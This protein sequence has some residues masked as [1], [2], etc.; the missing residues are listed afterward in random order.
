MNPASVVVDTGPIRGAAVDFEPK[1]P[2]GRSPNRLRGRSR[3]K[4]ART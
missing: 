1:C 4:S 2:A 3:L